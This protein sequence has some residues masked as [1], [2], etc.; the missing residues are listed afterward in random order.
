MVLEGGEM[1]D[2]EKMIRNAFLA[3]TER[4]IVSVR[5]EEAKAASAFESLE[6]RIYWAGKAEARWDALLT[7]FEIFGQFVGKPDQKFS[8]G[9]DDGRGN[10]ALGAKDAYSRRK[11]AWQA[12]MKLMEEV[13]CTKKS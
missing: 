6:K 1:T 12:A 5:V 11:E 3:F 8:L 13:Q 4:M 2:F 7:F 10:M 9:T